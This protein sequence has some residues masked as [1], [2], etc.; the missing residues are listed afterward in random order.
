MAE[1]GGSPVESS[2]ESPLKVLD[3]AGFVATL[4][5]NS[6]FEIERYLHLGEIVSASTVAESISEEKQ[7]RLG[8]GHF[9][10]WVTTFRDEAGEVV[11]RQRFRVLKFKPEA[12]G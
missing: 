1:R 8:P 9:V 4:A 5:S 6:E 2:G 3:D 12:A 10:T 7:T 11:A